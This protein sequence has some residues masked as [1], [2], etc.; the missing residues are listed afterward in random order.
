MEESCGVRPADGNGSH[1]NGPR[2]RVHLESARGETEP[3]R[4]VP[5]GLSDVLGL[6][7]TPC[8]GPW[9]VSEERKIPTH[10]NAYTVERGQ[11]TIREGFRVRELLAGYLEAQGAIWGGCPAGR[12]R[13][14]KC[15]GPMTETGE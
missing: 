11:G 5:H 14:H 7:L 15:R 12:Q 1:G 10:M 2:V 4:P 6:L 8:L 9:K 3:R 13:A